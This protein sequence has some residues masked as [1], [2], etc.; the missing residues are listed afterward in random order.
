M[1]GAVFGLGFWVTMQV[2]R[3]GTA[4]VVYF[5]VLF[6]AMVA[7]DFI[8]T[9]AWEIARYFNWPSH[10]ATFVAALAAG[11]MWSAVLFFLP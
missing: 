11:Y 8:A 3:T 6:S 4:P 10:S 9:I 1:G 2:M 5:S 7:A